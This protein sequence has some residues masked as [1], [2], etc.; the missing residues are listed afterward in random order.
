M[1][2]YYTP[3]LFMLC[4][5]WITY[6]WYTRYTFY[7]LPYSPPI[8]NTTT[9]NTIFETSSQ[10]SITN[11]RGEITKI[12]WDNTT[13]QPR[14]GLWYPPEVMH[15]CNSQSQSQSHTTQSSASL[16]KY[17][18]A[19]YF[20]NQIIIDQT[21]V[22][23]QSVDYTNEDAQFEMKTIDIL[24]NIP[25]IKQQGLDEQ[26]WII[27]I[28]RIVPMTNT[29]VSDPSEQM[30]S[31]EE[32][33]YHDHTRSY[34]KNATEFGQSIVFTSKH[35]LPS[36][37]LYF[38]QNNRVLY[39]GFQTYSMQFKIPYVCLPSIESITFPFENTPRTL[40]YKT[41]RNT[42]ITNVSDFTPI[43]NIDNYTQEDIDYL[44]QYLKPHFNTIGKT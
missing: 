38:E 4:L 12:E 33:F 31:V 21:N 44:E 40:T 26:Y 3:I 13:L 6:I 36:N 19:G 5:V 8:M 1:T 15:G 16:P 34:M 2:T 27:H 10:K 39:N 24:L 7:K 28:L 41:N 37:A 23:K 43:T 18:V 9:T 14:K 17:Y 11:N 32:G 25:S 20:P 35:I 22:F 30:Y 42:G 29:N